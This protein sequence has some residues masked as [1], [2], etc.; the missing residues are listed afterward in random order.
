MRALSNI[1][2]LVFSKPQKIL[3]QFW[4]YFK[5][6]ILSPAKKAAVQEVNCV[7]L[8]YIILFDSSKIVEAMIEK[9]GHTFSSWG[10]ASC[11]FSKVFFS[12]SKCSFSIFVV[13]KVLIPGL[14]CFYKR[15]KVLLCEL[16]LG[17]LCHTKSSVTLT[18]SSYSSC[19]RIFGHVRFRSPD[20]FI[21]TSL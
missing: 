2:C 9:S 19:L 16:V 21:V 3:S 8:P 13:M 4:L 10:S 1:L 14:H 18:V 7:I 11:P 12:L 5:Q 15:Q 20:Y 17:K 6:I